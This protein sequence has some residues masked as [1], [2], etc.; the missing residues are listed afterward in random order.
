MKTKNKVMAIGCALACIALVAFTS[1]TDSEF[2][3]VNLMHGKGAQL[4]AIDTIIKNT[5]EALL[6]LYKSIGLQPS[7]VLEVR[8]DDA[9]APQQMRI[10][11]E[12]KVV[13][14]R[15]DGTPEEVT[16]D[17]KAHVYVFSTDEAAKGKELQAKTIEAI[18]TDD[19]EKDFEFTF[20]TDEKEGE[21]TSV[22]IS[23]TIDKDGVEQTTVTVNGQKLSDAD[24]QKWL[25]EHESPATQIHQLHGAEGK[26][27]MVFISKQGS[28]E[29]EIISGVEPENE[30]IAVAII[31][32]VAKNATNNSAYAKKKAMDF[33]LYPNPTKDSF[34]AE[35]DLKSA[36]DATL[37]VTHAN[38]Q[39]VLSKKISGGNGKQKE[40]ISTQNW[41]SG[42]YLISVSSAEGVTTQKLVVE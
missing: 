36:L 21:N 33:N 12:R 37:T 32:E 30:E 7:T 39:V 42:I 23:K 20:N 15:G 19:I 35:I 41:A 3:Q 9:K 16:T 6:S 1:K 13:I 8:I 4:T 34:T 25:N 26:Q 5:P 28:A 27:H 11:T 38:G 40:L 31:K 17:K 2:I 22:E 14:Q 29:T 10:E 18:V 24:A